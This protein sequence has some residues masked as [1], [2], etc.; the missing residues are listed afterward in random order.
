MVKSYKKYLQEQ[1]AFY[2]KKSKI[3]ENNIKDY[4]ELISVIHKPTGKVHRMKHDFM[5]VSQDNYL[6]FVYNQKMLESKVMEDGSYVALFLTLTL[7]S[8]YHLYSKT[9][10][11]LNP[12]YKNGNS[13]SVGYKLLNSSFREIYKDFKVKRTLK[14]IYYSRVIEP[15]KNLTPHLHAI[16]Y[17]KK[18]YVDNLINHI[19]NIIKK[20]SLGRYDIELIKDLSRSTSYLLK[21]I[22]KTTNPQNEDDYHFFNGWKKS[23]KIRVFT[24]SNLG[25]ERYL[26]KT[27]NH[28]LNLSKGLKGINPIERVLSVCNIVVETKDRD[29]KEVKIKKHLIDNGDYGVKVERTRKVEIRKMRVFDKDTMEDLREFFEKN[30][31]FKRLILHCNSTNNRLALQKFEELIEE[32]ISKVELRKRGFNNIKSSLGLSHKGFFVQS[33]GKLVVDFSRFKWEKV[34]NRKSIL[35]T[36]FKSSLDDFANV[37]KNDIDKMKKFFKNGFDDIEDNDMNVTLERARLEALKVKYNEYIRQ[38]RKNSLEVE[39]R[40]NR[41]EYVCGDMNRFL[42]MVGS[43]KVKFYRYKIDRVWIV[44]IKDNKKIYDSKEYGVEHFFKGK[45]R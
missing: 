7:S 17:V 31:Y 41:W 20:N 35:D 38:N 8:S 10:K 25:M 9:T 6:W 36:S 11:K 26:F 18:E 2:V 5:Q 27:I 3:I 39:L 12:S 34:N 13:I 37:D 33:C 14:K 40:P 16:I 30:E 43:F 44:S 24:I 4:K 19:Q 23:N 42:D 15:H 21:Y 22:N 1:R 28:Q 29:S 32:L 45:L